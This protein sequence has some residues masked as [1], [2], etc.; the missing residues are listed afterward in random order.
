[1][2][3]GY[4]RVR[5]GTNHIII[6]VALASG[7]TVLLAD[8]FFSPPAPSRAAGAGL[9]Q[10][11]D[12]CL[13]ADGTLRVVPSGDLCPPGERELF[14]FEASASAPLPEGTP[15]PPGPSGLPGPPGPPGPHGPPGPPGS[16]G[17]EVGSGYEVVI[18]RFVVAPKQVGS[19]VARCPAGKVVLGGGVRFDP[20]SASSA[21]ERSISV[22]KSSPVAAGEGGEGGPGWGVTVKHTG[23]SSGA[24]ALVV[25]A[26]CAMVH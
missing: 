11:V 13:Q 26:I 8:R 21:V 12:A 18:S 14:W 2:A 15:G 25:S 17:A 22:S 10:R 9:V 24:I 6:I 16:G 23:D 3:N 1:M 19:G 20:E 4:R 5:P 7:V